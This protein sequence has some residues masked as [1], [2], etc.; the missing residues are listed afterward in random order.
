MRDTKS[1]LWDQGS[2]ECGKGTINWVMLTLLELPGS[3]VCS[4]PGF[5]LVRPVSCSP[6]TQHH[7]TTRWKVQTFSAMCVIEQLL[8]SVSCCSQRSWKM[9]L[10]CVPLGFHRSCNWVIMHSIPCL[11]SSPSRR[12][13]TSFSVWAFPPPP[14]NYAR[15]QLSGN[16][17]H[18]N[19][20]R[21]MP[22]TRFLF[23]HP[24]LSLL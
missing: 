17:D 9:L 4:V 10:L 16:G 7:E 6:L 2:R 24:P 1:I 19:L 3:H 13:N 5:S 8:R 20:L 23:G 22:N 18:W 11:L 14:C 15:V 21:S 12:P